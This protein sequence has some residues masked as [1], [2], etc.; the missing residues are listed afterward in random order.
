MLC[1]H[2]NITHREFAKGA[3]GIYTVADP[4]GGVTCPPP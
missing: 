2:S 3:D 1:L 4:E